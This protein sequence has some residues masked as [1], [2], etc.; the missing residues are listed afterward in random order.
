MTESDLP[1]LP[2]AIRVLLLADLDFNSACQGR[3]GTRLPGDMTKPFAQIRVPG[4][5]DLGGGG[6]KPLVQVDGWAAPADGEDPEIVVWRIA[7]RAARVLRTARNVQYQSMHYTPRVLD[8]P[9]A[10]EDTSRGPDAPLYR[11]LIRAEITIHNR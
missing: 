1:W 8:G 11:A 7:T 6:Y 9:M 10:T 3:A 5:L 4:G 2:G